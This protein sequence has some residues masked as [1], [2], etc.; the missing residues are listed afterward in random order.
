MMNKRKTVAYKDVANAV[1]EDP[2]LH[3]LSDIIPKTMPLAEAIQYRRKKLMEM[4]EDG[5]VAAPSTDQPLSAE[6]TV[7]QDSTTMLQ[8]SISVPT[9]AQST[10]KIAI[11][12]ADADTVIGEINQPLS[13]MEEDNMSDS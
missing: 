6:V 3:F 5:A 4:D 11:A 9:A 12:I 8:E 13:T 10:A 1:A 7:G 2:R